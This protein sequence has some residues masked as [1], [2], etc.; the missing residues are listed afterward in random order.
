MLQQV[1]YHR[2]PGLVAALGRAG[3]CSMLP[4][5]SSSEISLTVETLV[6]AYA[7]VQAPVLDQCNHLSHQHSLYQPRLPAPGECCRAFTV[8]AASVPAQLA[9][10]G[11][12][13]SSL[14]RTK[15][16]VECGL[17]S[18]LNR[19]QLSATTVQGP[20]HDS[21][22][23]LQNHIMGR[24]SMNSCLMAGGS[25]W[26]VRKRWECHF[27][28]FWPPYGCPIIAC[29]SFH[30]GSGIYYGFLFMI[31]TCSGISVVQQI[32]TKVWHHCGGCA[33]G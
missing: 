22:V 11:L 30:A 26:F 5:E 13:L 33:P 19:L 9:G 28:A 25:T 2:R 29:H 6:T 10:H 23:L 1:W 16:C 12:A 18:R 4:S 20:R 21:D 3:L 17:H 24:L 14:Q 32:H 8:G 15:H 31:V 7:A 27:F